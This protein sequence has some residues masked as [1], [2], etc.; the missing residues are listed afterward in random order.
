MTFELNTLLW[1]VFLLF[2]LL[3]YQ[4]YLVPKTHGFR[5]GLGSRDEARDPSIMQ[6]RAART[7]NNHLQSMALFTPLVLIAQQMGVSNELTV[8]GAGL[9]LTARVIFAWCYI[10]GVPVLRSV[11]WGAS[12]V[13]LTMITIA[14]VRA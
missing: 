8:W 2:A 14:I 6:G 10:G 13:G 7:V 5:W 4:G 3:A 12:V 1:T 11:A 9:F